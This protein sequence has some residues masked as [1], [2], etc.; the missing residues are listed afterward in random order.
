MKLNQSMTTDAGAPEWGNFDFT[1]DIE[2][3]GV[4]NLTFIPV[5]KSAKRR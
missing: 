3:R 5:L 2:K 4:V 1:I